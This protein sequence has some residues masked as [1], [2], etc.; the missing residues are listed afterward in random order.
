MKGAELLA[1]VFDQIEEENKA[2]LQETMQRET[3]IGKLI[4]WRQLKDN[5]RKSQ[6]LLG[7]Y[8]MKNVL[9]RFKV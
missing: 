7:H 8:K 2:R 3:F 6:M 9:G 1:S 4:N 5:S